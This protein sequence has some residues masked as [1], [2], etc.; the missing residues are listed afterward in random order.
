MYTLLYSLQICQSENTKSFP[1]DIGKKLAYG[2]NMKPSTP[3]LYGK[4]SVNSPGISQLISG[5]S[6][7]S[8]IFPR[9]SLLPEHFFILTAGLD[10]R[11]KKYLLSIS[12]ST[13]YK[14]Q[15]LHIRRTFWKKKRL[16]ISIIF[17]LHWDS[18]FNWSKLQMKMK[19]LE[20]NLMLCKFK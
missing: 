7:R 11:K 13:L 5:F 6:L 2:S 1:T 14:K 20:K 9:L 15:L 4:Y 3:P 8:H 19:L 18:E 10:L 16:D 17:N 12:V